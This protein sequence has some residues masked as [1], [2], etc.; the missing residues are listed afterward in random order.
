MISKFNDNKKF[1]YKDTVS[2]DFRPSVFRQSITP[3]PPIK[4]LK[5]LS[6]SVSNSQRNLRKCVC[7]AL[8]HGLALCHIVLDRR[9]AR[10]WSSAISQS[11]AP[12]RRVLTKWSRAMRHSAGLWSSP[13]PHSAGHWSSFKY[14]FRPGSDLIQ[15]VWF[16]LRTVYWI[17]NYFLD[18]DPL[19]NFKN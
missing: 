10:D 16:L 6:I 4:T 18:P 1:I 19:D 8:D 5:I 13:L 15:H 2:R 12:I 11:A 14:S 9:I 7:S 17:Q 3:K